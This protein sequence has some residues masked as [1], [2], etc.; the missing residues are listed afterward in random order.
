MKNKE[1]KN[2][3]NLNDQKIDA[4]KV[5]GGK[6]AINISE[7]DRGIPKRAKGPKSGLSRND[8]FKKPFQ[9]HSNDGDNV[10]L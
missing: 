8:G 6:K 9:S 10:S 2:I 3:N 5:Q 1:D 7:L 4:D